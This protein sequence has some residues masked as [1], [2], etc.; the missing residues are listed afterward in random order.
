MKM[1]ILSFPLFGGGLHHLVQICAFVAGLCL[2]QSA[3]GQQ[4]TVYEAVQWTRGVLGTANLTTGANGALT[5]TA[6]GSTTWNAGAISTQR[7]LGDGSIKFQGNAGGQSAFIVGFNLV[8]KNELS[9]DMDHAIYL[10]ADNLAQ[11]YH[12][13]TAGVSLGAF[14][15][16]TV[17]TIAR[18]GSTVLF[19]KDSALMHTSTTASAGIMMVDCSFVKS[20]PLGSQLTSCQIATGDLDNDGMADNWEEDQLPPLHSWTDVTN[21]LPGNDADLDGVSNLLEFQTRTMATDSLSRSVP[22]NWLRATNSQLNTDLTSNSGGIKKTTP[23]TVEKFDARA[24]ASQMIVG[25]GQ[26][27]FKVTPG[28]LMTAGFNTSNVMPTATSVTTDLEWSILANANGTFAINPNTTD[29]SLADPLGTYTADTV[30]CIQR[31]AGQMRFMKDGVVIHT[32]ALASVGPLYPNVWLSSPTAELTLAHIDTGDMDADGLPDVWERQFLKADSGWN[33]LLAF[34]PLGNADATVVINGQTVSSGD[35]VINLDE[36]IDGTSPSDSLSKSESVVWRSDLVNATATSGSILGG[37]KKTST[38]AGYNARALGTQAILEDGLVVFQVSGNGI[39]TLGLN[40]S[41]AMPLATNGTPNTAI[42]TPDLEWAF[43]T[44]AT[45]TYTVKP[46][47]AVVTPTAALNTYDASTRF[48]IQRVGGVVRFFRNGALVHT[49]AAKSTGTLYVNVWLSTPAQEVTLARVYTGDVDNDLMPDAWELSYLANNAGFAELDAFKAS[50]AGVAS[51]PDGDG[52]QNLDEYYDGTNPLLPQLKSPVV[53]WKTNP[54]NYFTL[55]GTWGAVKKTS[56]VVGWNADAVASSMDAANLLVPFAIGQTA[57]LTFTAT[58]GSTLAMGFTAVDNNRAQ[59][60]LEYMIQLVPATTTVPAQAG[61]WEG[62]GLTTAPVSKFAL[63]AFDANTRFS[64]RRV[65]RQ[66]D[67]LKDSQ[68]LYSSVTPVTANLMVDSSFNTTNSE[69]TSARLYTGDV[70]EDGLPDE[71]EIYHWRRS[72]PSVPATFTFNDLRD[73]VRPQWDIDNDGSTNFQEFCADTDPVSSVSRLQ[74]VTWLSPVGV[75]AD[76]MVGNQGALSKNQGVAAA[77][78]AGAVSE[79]ALVSDGS[80]IFSASPTGTVAIGLT[81]SNLNASNLDIEYSLVLSSTANASV[82]EG[83]GSSTS[84]LKADLGSYTA[85]TIFTIRRLGSTIEYLKNGVLAYTSTVAVSVPLFADCSINTANHSISM[86]R[87]CDRVQ[88]NDN[89]GLPDEWEAV[90]LGLGISLESLNEFEPLG[91]DDNDD[92]KNVDEYLN[93][94]SA[95]L[96]DTD[97][98]GMSDRWELDWGL[99]ATD[100]SNKYTDLD[101]DGLSNLAEFQAGTNPFDPDSDDDE[102][103]DGYEMAQGLNPLNPQDAMLDKDSD[104]VPNVWEFTKGSL[105]NNASSLPVWDAI[106]DPYINVDSPTSSPPR[107]RNPYNAYISLPQDPHYRAC[108]LFMRGRHTQNWDQFQQVSK[109]VAYVAEGGASR[110]CGDEGVRLEISNSNS[111]SS[112]MLRGESVMAGFIFESNGLICQPLSG[113]APKIR[114]VNCLFRSVRSF[115]SNATHGGAFTNQGGNVA[116]EHCT[117]FRSNS[118]LTNSYPYTPVATLANLS[119]SIV[120]KNCILWD[121]EYPSNTP[122]SGLTNSVTIQSSLIQGGM[123]GSLNQDPKL[124]SKGYLTADSTPCVSAGLALGIGKDIHGQQRSSTAPSLGAVEWVNLDGDSLPDWWEQFWFGNTTYTNTSKPFADRPT[125]SLLEAYL[126]SFW[127]FFLPVTDQ[128]GDLLPDEFERQYFGSIRFYGPNDD[129]D[130]DQIPN[131]VELVYRYISPFNMNPAVFQAFNLD[132]DNDTLPDFFEIFYW[133]N[134]SSQ[135]GVGDADHDGLTNYQEFVAGSNPNLHPG[136]ND[137]SGPDGLVDATELAIFGNLDQTGSGDYDQD[138]LSNATEI[139]ITGTDPKV[140]DTNGDGYLDGYLNS[141]LA[142]DSDGDG[143][144][145]TQETALGTNPRLADTDGDGVLDGTD[146]YPLNAMMQTAP[147]QSNPPDT[148]API[149]TLDEPL[150]AQPQQ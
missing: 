24:F 19:Y 18:V 134:S 105:A 79:K 73:L 3:W 32:A 55:T 121:D 86:A 11:V 142:T 120:L 110:G 145:N 10:R 60:D 48:M 75:T 38:T 63:G 89:D 111:N 148:T 66:I 115:G 102:M 87:M 97:G 147:S 58:P 135:T 126:D 109:K 125:L 128:D 116:M 131:W 133:G 78:N 70:D 49:A 35:T 27:M 23:G 94:T 143:L 118:C 62:T 56:T 29:I 113:G 99:A 41:N 101:S 64:I 140:A 17:F 85:S 6:G 95:A 71:W 5:K 122:I 36:W 4:P 13:A 91:D 81:A 83:N 33:D 98:D 26:I 72:S 68:V 82:Y 124:I 12:G 22:I 130:G 15:S 40:A 139:W 25:D 59:T 51:D 104:N 69:I 2:I 127:A 9:T 117:F 39:M 50:G 74:S 57:R 7:M 150:D 132:F 46:N 8:D 88:D 14:T 16:S 90:Q 100:A 53:L 54:S 136:D 28:T 129:P 67:Y 1:S 20:G 93:G 52:V 146:V 34:A 138:G 47:A 43:T 96:A 31:A 21:F 107:F 37:L 137:P 65:A 103:F 108:I 42:L 30:F 112:W 61:V 123:L 80:F 77:Y 144:S 141:L 119:G 76:T 44:T 149:L 45:G 106:V 114:F 92:V 84:V